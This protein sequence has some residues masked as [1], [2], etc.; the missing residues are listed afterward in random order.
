MSNLGQSNLN[1]GNQPR[2]HSRAGVGTLASPLFG[3]H[4]VSSS[5]RIV[6]LHEEMYDL[7]ETTAARCIMELVK[8]KT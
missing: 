3:V 5:D 4:P 7:V 1:P 6:N 2:M 8:G